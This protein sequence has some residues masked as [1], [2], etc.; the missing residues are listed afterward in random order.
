MAKAGDPRPARSIK[1]DFDKDFSAFSYGGAVLTE[2]VMRRMGIRRKLVEFLPSRNRSG[3][4]AGS[5]SAYATLAGM[6]CGGRGF[7]SAE[8]LRTHQDLAEVFGLLGSVPE[9]ATQYRVSCDLAGLQQ[10]IKAE[11]YEKVQEAPCQID[12]HG[13]EKKQPETRRLVPAE[14]E[15]MSAGR[16]EAFADLLASTALAAIGMQPNCISSLFGFF[17]IHGDATDLEVEGNCFD[18]GRVNHEGNKSLRWG[19][20]KLGPVTIAEEVFPGASDEGTRAPEMLG[21]AANKVVSKAGKDRKALALFD[22]AYC[23]D[24]VLQKLRALGWN[25]IVCANQMRVPMTVVAGN[26]PA[27]QWKTDRKTKKAEWAESELA[28]FNYCA[29]TWDKPETV[30]ARRWREKGE[31]KGVWHYSFLVT[32]LSP[33]DLPKRRVKKYDFE[34]TVWMMYGTKQGHENYYKRT[35]S[36]LGLHNPP[37]GRLGATQV[38]YTLGSVAANIQAVISYRVV[39][40]KE[41]GIRMRR[42]LRE[43]VVLTGQLIRR[44]GGVLFVRLAGAELTENHRTR[45]LEAFANAEAL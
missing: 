4:Y 23:E 25:Y 1:A 8:L 5:V 45:W 12:M 7:R 18:A 42:F 29:E 10:R 17:A 2:R 3:G 36:D 33:E 15:E 14:P 38:H 37:S 21:R 6:L 44:S 19:T 32:D 31:L 22:A 28:V 27:W 20:I 43:Y 30:I 34:Q 13:N 35:L 39:T 16:K 11:H 40:K 41:R 9:E 24:A 26:L